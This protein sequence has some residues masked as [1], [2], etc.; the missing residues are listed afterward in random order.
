MTTYDNPG[1][2]GDVPPDPNK[3]ESTWGN[4]IR[5]R[6][7]NHFATI[8]DRDD[9]YSGIGGPIQGMCC[10][11][12]D[13]GSDPGGAFLEYT[14]AG[15]YPPWNTSW[16]LVGVGAAVTSQSGVTAETLITGLAATG[17]VLGADI[18][19]GRHI[20]TRVVFA[21][22]TDAAAQGGFPGGFPAFVIGTL[23]DDL[24]V[25]GGQLDQT[26]GICVENTFGYRAELENLAT[27]DG[28][29]FERSVSIGPGTITDT[30]GSVASSTRP[31]TL[32]MYDEGPA[33]GPV[34]P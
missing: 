19:A 7:V 15:W 18:P 26:F 34:A 4:A 20:R 1:A 29:A 11:V 8:S 21:G 28:S 24:V 23:Y 13:M 31:A 16:G 32:R 22:K 17:Q 33:A 10:V 5:D 12:D 3:V 6:V 9:F 27:S 2:I 25:S 30:V 14:V